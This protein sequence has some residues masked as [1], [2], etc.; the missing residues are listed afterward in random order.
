MTER[1]VNYYANLFDDDKNENIS[2]D[3]FVLMLQ[4]YNKP[5]KKV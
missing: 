3:E 2:Q 1:S 5:L 4:K